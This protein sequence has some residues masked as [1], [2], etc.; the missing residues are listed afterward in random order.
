MSK[1]AERLGLFFL[2][3]PLFV[4]T[5][6]LVPHFHYIVFQVEI[7]VFVSLAIMEVRQIL[8][9][10]MQVYPVAHLVAAGVLPPLAAAASCVFGISPILI[11]FA[12]AAAIILIFIFEFAYSFSGH[13]EAS[14]ERLS[15]GFFV[16]LYPG[17]LVVFLSLLT[18]WQNAGAIICTLFLMVFGCDSFAWLFGILLGKGN[19]GVLP[20]SPNKSVAGFIGGYAGSIAGCLVGRFLWPDA[21]PG[22]IWKLIAVAVCIATAAIIGD[23]AESILKRSGGLKDSGA[24]MPGRGGILDTIDSVLLSSPV[25]Y[26][27]CGALFSFQSY[28]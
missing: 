25:F 6:L 26:F 4:A 27:L 7:I 14:I 28:E 23:I 11:L 8:A 16:I 3:I 12:G 20:A 24:V 18:Q 21:F 17:Y 10:R 2:G 19:R 15:S 22:A 9:Q 5:V 13:F 1:F